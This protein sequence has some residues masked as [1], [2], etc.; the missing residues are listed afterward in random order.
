M[1]KPAAHA[2]EGE[3]PAA[4]IDPQ[5]APPFEDDPVSHSL[6]AARRAEQMAQQQQPQQPQLSQWK[7]DFLRAYPE[8]VRDEEAAF[9]TRSS[10]L[11]ALRRG[12]RDDTEEMNAAVLSGFNRMRDAVNNISHEPER[13][14]P[15]VNAPEPRRSVQYSAPVT[16]GAPSMA[17]GGTAPM[18][19]TLSPEE[20][21]MAHMSYRDM[22]KEKAE[23]LYWEMKRKMLKARR[24]GTLNE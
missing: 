7:A 21:A 14:A 22:P 20:V 5:P 2:V 23:R 16:R 24:D 6:G 15:P 9:L 3:A 19:I 4:P 10:Y 18:R 8:L 13:E 17:T 11:A 1:P 12:I